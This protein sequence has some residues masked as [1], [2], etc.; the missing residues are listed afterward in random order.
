MVLRL[1]AGA[2]NIKKDAKK[3]SKANKNI[4]KSKKGFPD[5]DTS[6]KA[7]K[8]E[9]YRTNSKGEEPVPTK[10]EI[11]ELIAGTPIRYLIKKVVKATSPEKVLTKKQFRKE[12]NKQ[13]E[14][15]QPFNRGGFVKTYAKGASPRKAKF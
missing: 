3:A 12:F 11:D 4:V 5:F 14:E 2:K 6:F 8:K 7:Y 9:W 15:K 13:L 10:K 1:I